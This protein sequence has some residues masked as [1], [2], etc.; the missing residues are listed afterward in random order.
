MHSSVS[1]KI[2]NLWV[3]RGERYLCKNMSF[4]LSSG[5]IVK[6]NGENG[7]G[8][9]TLLKVVVGVLRPLEG[10]IHYNGEDVSVYRDVLLKDLLY[11]GHHSGV[12]SVFS[13]SENLRWYFPE[14]SDDEISN[15]L[16]AVSLSGYEETPSNQ[17][18]AG[19]KRRI[20]LARLWLTDKP[21]WLLDEPFTALDVKGVAALEKRM[22]TH[23]NNNGIIMLTTHQDIDPSLNLKDI[24][25]SL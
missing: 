23:I 25:L 1:L 4:S 17:L 6:I 16:D 9:S 24:S 2:S 12:K 8:K 18:S 11:I 10:D 19:Q 14:A 21:L 20:A 22:K 15:A 13:V 3:E 5:D 7:A